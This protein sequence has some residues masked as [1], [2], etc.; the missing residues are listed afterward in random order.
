MDVNGALRR[1]LTRSVLAC[2]CAP[3]RLVRPP[4]TPTTRETRSESWRALDAVRPASCTS[5]LRRS[6]MGTMPP[7]RRQPTRRTPRQCRRQRH[8]HICRSSLCPSR[9]T[10]KPKWAVTA[11]RSDGP[12]QAS[13][14]AGERLILLC[15]ADVMMAAYTDREVAKTDGLCTSATPTAQVPAGAGPTG[16][17]H[18][19]YAQAPIAY[20]PYPWAEPSS[21]ACPHPLSAAWRIG[22]FGHHLCA[23][24][25]VPAVFS[26]PSHFT[27][28]L[29]HTDSLFISHDLRPAFQQEARRMPHS[30]LWCLL[31]TMPLPSRDLALASWHQH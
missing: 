28:G 11:S 29:I 14:N 31:N 18:P 16:W 23:M 9:G 27:G 12:A 7:L 15:A 30:R 10:G 1:V 21:S 3:L 5:C 24:H 8:I 13:N 4:L 26:H 6:G 22:P 20:R 19:R 17:N 2:G 25:G